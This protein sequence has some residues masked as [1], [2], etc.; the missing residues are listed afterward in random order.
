MVLGTGSSHLWL[1]VSMQI[2]KHSRRAFLSFQLEVPALVGVLT[3]N[4]QEVLSL[5][6]PSLH[7]LLHSQLS[8]SRSAQVPSR[9][10]V[11]DTSLQDREGGS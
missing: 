11:S 9:P 2:Q 8:V 3:S 5:F 6:S 10:W 7:H 1:G 4:P